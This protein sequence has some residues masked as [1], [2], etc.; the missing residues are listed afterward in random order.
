MQQQP[1]PFTTVVRGRQQLDPLDMG[2]HGVRFYQTG[3]C[4][5]TAPGRVQCS[6]LP[7]L[8][9][10]KFMGYVATLT[11]DSKG[12]CEAHTAKTGRCSDSGLCAITS[13][14]C[15][16]PSSF[17]DDDPYCTIQRDRNLPTVDTT[18]RTTFGACW[19]EAT[20]EHFC[21]WRFEDCDDGE[22]FLQPEEVRARGLSCPCEETHI[23]ACMTFSDRSWCALR[24]EL[25]ESGSEDSRGVARQ[26]SDRLGGIDGIDC[27]MCSTQDG[28]LLSQLVPT[29]QPV[30]PPTQ[31]PVAG[32]VTEPV[33]Q[34]GSSSSGKSNSS[35]A[36]ALGLGIP[37]ACLVVIALGFFVRYKHKRRV[38]F[39]VSGVE[40][41]S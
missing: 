26:R 1:P 32:G 4:D 10:G 34:A 9:Q 2:D 15:A 31:A 3:T 27:R 22:Q 37:A 29:P 40:G 16:D 23:A 13:D 21:V 25:C 18:S 17:V 19:N 24:E 8:C 30:A 7:E 39:D 5:P 6:L 11:E 35:K 14:S 33:P 36:L 28:Q 41:L 20:Q 12:V 38:K